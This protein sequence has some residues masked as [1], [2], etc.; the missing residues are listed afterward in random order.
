MKESG[1]GVTIGRSAQDG[2]LI[3]FIDGADDKHGENEGGPI[4]RIYLNDE[5]LFE[6]PPYPG[7]GG[8]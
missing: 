8:K 3:V 1:V 2:T 7:S 4:M 6:N 5:A